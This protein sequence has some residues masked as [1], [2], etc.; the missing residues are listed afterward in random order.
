MLKTS[1]N[2][3]CGFDALPH[4]PGANRRRRDKDIVDTAVAAGRSRR[5]P[6][7]STAAGLVETLK[8]AG[9]FTVFA[10]TDEAFAKLP[11]G[12]VESLLKPEN[13]AKLRRILTYHVV[14]GKVMAA[15]VVKMSSA[16]TVSGDTMAIAAAGGARHGRQ[17]ARR[18]D[19]YRRQQR[20][21]SRD[22]HRAAAEGQITS[23]RG[24]SILLTGAT[25]YVG[26]RLLRSLE[27]GGRRVRCLAREP[28]ELG[29]ACT[30][31]RGDARRLSR[32]TSLDRALAS[33]HT[34]YYLVHSMA[35]DAEFA[36][37]DRPPRSTSAAL[38]RRR[39]AP[40]RLSWRPHR[41]GRVASEH[42]KSRAETGEHLR[43]G[44]VPV[45][46]FR[47]AIVIGAG[48]LSFEM[49]AALVER[50]ARHGVPSLGD[51]PDP[52][53]RDCRR[54]GVPDGRAG[55]AR[56]QASRVFEIGGPRRFRTAT[57]CAVR[58]PARAAPPAAAGAIPDAAPVRAVARARGA[59]A[60]AGGTCP[61][62]G[63]EN[64]TVVRS[65][66]RANVRNRTDAARS[67]R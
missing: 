15:D 12:T 21:H 13:K 29:G 50:L 53:D 18:Q 5:S 60:G 9:P 4:R 20:R 64:P 16:K 3:C 63:P 25:G 48:S 36:A 40:H 22:R 38:Q 1:R 23:G 26:G 32:H 14:A 24:A 62:R 67:T 37:V 61:G 56:W 39:R 31:D 44:G 45:V 59:G 27:E 49:L 2:R 7:R 30:D 28:R 34:A 66:P 55:P 35:G 65:M 57:C 52:A 10:P 54:R 41:S 42:L 58:A 33:V 19:R 47:A 6:R 43:A 51:D 17:R 8:G 46:E 11:A